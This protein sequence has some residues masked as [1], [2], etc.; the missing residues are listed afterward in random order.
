MCRKREQK[1]YNYKTKSSKYV[2]KLK[3]FLKEFMG[4]INNVY[5]I[6]YGCI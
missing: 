1:I 6:F 4:L 3:Q 5:F 2:Q